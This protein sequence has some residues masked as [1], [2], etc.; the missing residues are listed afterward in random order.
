MARMVHL[1]TNK[2]HTFQHHVRLIG[3]S[4]SRTFVFKTTSDLWEDHDGGIIMG[5]S[6]ETLLFVT[7][8]MKGNNEKRS[9]FT[10]SI[11][12]NC[13][14]DLQKM[15]VRSHLECWFHIIEWRFETRER[16]W[17][18]GLQRSSFWLFRLWHNNVEVGWSNLCLGF[19]TWLYDVKRR[20]RQHHD[21]ESGTW[22]MRLPVFDHCTYPMP[23]IKWRDK[24]ELL[25][26]APFVIA[27]G[28]KR[29]KGDTA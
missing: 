20:W 13:S 5:D 10:S 28:V 3:W 21:Y 1:T 6:G 11:I 8:N 18:G 22:K 14:H 23:I 7:W 27:C 25:I 26:T 17:S 2:I 24:S 12:I 19:R 9:M 29:A 15:L 4:I 16:L